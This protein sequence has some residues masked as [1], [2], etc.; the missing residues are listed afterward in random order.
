M[1]GQLGHRAVAPN[2]GK[3]YLHP[4]GFMCTSCQGISSGWM[5]QDKMEALHPNPRKSIRSTDQDPAVHSL[6]DET[7]AYFLVMWSLVT[8]WPSKR[9]M[10]RWLYSASAG[11]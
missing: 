6:G 11:E 3:D 8:I 9:W 10:I 4:I 2:D 5:N 7:R 1:F